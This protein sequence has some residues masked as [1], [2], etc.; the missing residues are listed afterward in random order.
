MRLYALVNVNKRIVLRKKNI[1]RS[2]N[3]FSLFNPPPPPPHTHTHPHSHLLPQKSNGRSLSSSQKDN[4]WALLRLL[5]P[6]PSLPLK[7]K[8]KKKKKKC[9][10][11]GYWI[12]PTLLVK[13]DN[14][15]MICQKIKTKKNKIK[16]NNKKKTKKNRSY[17]NT[18]LML[19]YLL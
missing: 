15:F 6:S 9:V 8:K 2:E 16:N 14:F 19:P 17:W 3:I 7:K 18:I 1:S 13:P 4:L 5:H 11:L 10:C 12:K